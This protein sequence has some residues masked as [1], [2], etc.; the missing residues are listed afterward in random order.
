LT[1]TCVASRTCNQTPNQKWKVEKD[2]TVQFIGGTDKL[3]HCIDLFSGNTTNGAPVGL[4]ECIPNQKSQQW[5]FTAGP[6][7]SPGPGPPTPGPPTPGQ[8]TPAQPTPAQPTPG[9]PTPVQPTPAPGPPTP[10]QP[11]PVQPTP[12]Q[13][14]PGPGP[15]GPLH[16][17]DPFRYACLVDEVNQTLGTGAICSPKCSTSAMCPEDQQPGEFMRLVPPVCAALV[18]APGAAIDV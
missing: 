18:E 3:Q 13:P 17:G 7:P 6:G 11:T 2:G 16:Y 15:S 1:E 5:K 9:Q 12:S 8:P 14:T 10:G 4:W